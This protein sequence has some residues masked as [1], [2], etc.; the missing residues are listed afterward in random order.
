M[1]KQTPNKRTPKSWQRSLPF[2]MRPLGQE[3]GTALILALT[4]LVMLTLLG[5]VSLHRT[6]VDLRSTASF[7]QEQQMFY[8]VEG[9]LQAVLGDGASALVDQTASI[10]LPGRPSLDAGGVQIQGTLQLL[11]QGLPPKGTGFSAKHCAAR[12]MKVQI[13]GTRG[14]VSHSQEAVAAR[15]IC[16]G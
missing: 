4:F 12:Y 6:T 16:A 3:S 10:P 13:T 2:W 7:R 14:S 5:L 8:V 15:T 1:P 9:A 11:Y